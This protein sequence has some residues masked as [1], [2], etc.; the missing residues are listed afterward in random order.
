MA[1]YQKEREARV[2]GEVC[3]L[4]RSVGVDPDGECGRALA[5]EM[6][7]HRLEPQPGKGVASTDSR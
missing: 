7:R 6:V 5:A 4:L 2:M 1:D 3:Q